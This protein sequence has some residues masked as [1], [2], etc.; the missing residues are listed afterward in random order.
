MIRA[1][2][3]YWCEHGKEWKWDVGGSNNQ[4]EFVNHRHRG[5]SKDHQKA[6]LPIQL[7]GCMDE[8]V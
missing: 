3:S 7:I 8:K 6:L 1:I 5:M 4:P 2:P